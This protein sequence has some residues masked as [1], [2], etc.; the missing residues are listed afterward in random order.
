MRFGAGRVGDMA[1]TPMP[2]LRWPRDE[3]PSGGPEPADSGHAITVVELLIIGAIVVT[4]AGIGLPA[5][6]RYRNN[7]DVATAIVDIRTLEHEIYTYEGM[8]GKVPDQLEA[9][10]PLKILDPWKRPYQYVSKNSAKWAPDRRRDR[11]A[12]PLNEDFDL[13]SLGR[14]GLS[15]P[16]LTFKDSQDDIVRAQ[17]GAYVG[18]ASEY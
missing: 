14:D 2:V 8:E 10:K 16:Q 15:K 4:L 5:Y 9:V 11:S 6:S 13:Y 3:M 1:S 18:L 17:E 7:A 12:N